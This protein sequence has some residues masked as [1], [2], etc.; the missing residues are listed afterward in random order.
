MRLKK[1]QK[2]ELLKLIAA[3]LESDEINARAAEF[4]SPFEVSRQQVDFYR[5]TRKVNIEEIAEQAEFAALQTGL[6]QKAERVRKLKDLAALLEAD[7][8]DNDLLWTEEVKGVG[9]GTIAEIVDYLEFNRS[10]VDAYRGLLD[11]IA[12]EVGD[13]VQRQ[14]ITSGGKT[15]RTV[16]FDTGDL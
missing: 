13:R 15:L 1:A 14:D 9:S 5:K 2:E 7:L 11:D 10:E 4:K 16:G 8:F 6:A 3:G 12:K